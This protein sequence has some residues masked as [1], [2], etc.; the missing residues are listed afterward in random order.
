M[1]LL[2]TADVFVPNTTTV[3][4]FESALPVTGLDVLDMGCGVGPIAIAAALGGAKSVVGA[5]VMEEACA[6]ARR[7]AELNGVSDRVTFIRSH[8]FRD[9]K[10]LSFD[11]II[12]DAA[13]MSEEIARRSPWYPGS[14][15]T[16]GVDGTAVSIEVVENAPRS[17]RPGGRL[18]F[19]VLSLSRAA[20]IEAAA[21]RAF[22][23]GLT[24]VCEKSIPFP[25]DLA[26]DRAW[27][28]AQQKEG[29]IDYTVRGSRLCW[30]LTIYSGQLISPGP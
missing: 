13:G 22:G 16:G 8:A 20:M 26:N 15:P 1:S 7:N 18:V 25:P 14:I 27:L 30:R 12:S 5:D 17:L 4:L 9:L 28:E 11:L 10:D 21:Q 3:T 23:S 2:S 6:L 29:L 19:P 24:K